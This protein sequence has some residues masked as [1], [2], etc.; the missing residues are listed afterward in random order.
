LYADDPSLARLVVPRNDDTFPA[1]LARIDES[2]NITFRTETG[3]RE[4]AAADLVRWG[5][6]D[7]QRRGILVILADASSLVADAV[8]IDGDRLRTTCPLWGEV[9]LS[10]NQVRGILFAPPLGEPQFDRLLDRIRAASAEVTRVLLH[11]GDTI[12][13]QMVSLD[14]QGATV[15][16]LGR[17]TKMGAEQVTALVFPTVSQPRSAGNGVCCLLGFRDGSVV[18]ATQAT[19]NDGRLRLTTAGGLRLSSLAQIDMQY[20][21]KLVQTIEGGVTYLSDLVPVGYRHQPFLALARPLGVNRCV[22]GGQLRAQG[23]I[24]DKG[25]GMT[26]ASRVAY[27]LDGQYQRIAAQLAIDDRA[28]QG[29]SVIFRVFTRT[30][31]DGWREAYASPMVRGGETPLPISVGVGEAESMALVVEYADRVDELDYANWLDARLD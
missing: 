4:Y 28:G 9:S 2:W 22:T 13:G 24:F 15:R 7:D 5:G 27:R 12:S 16:V 14:E 18:R 10:R 29:G 6:R 23:L 3:Y 31:Q 8:D 1:E 17:D 19:L 20:E 26:S 11:N 30:R 21:T 25:L